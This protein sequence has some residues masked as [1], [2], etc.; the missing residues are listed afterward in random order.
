MSKGYLSPKHFGKNISGTDCGGIKDL[1]QLI[2]LFLGEK[3]YSNHQNECVFPQGNPPSVGS[4]V[5]KGL[6]KWQRERE[7]R[8]KIHSE[9]KAERKIGEVEGG[10]E[11]DK[12]VP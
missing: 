5:W 10:K 12:E 9:R 4:Q 6:L 7:R 2:F 8:K 11:R 3:G 1:I